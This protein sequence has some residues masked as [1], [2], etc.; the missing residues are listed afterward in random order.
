[1][2]LEVF[3]E[4]VRKNRILQKSVANLRQRERENE[5]REA[6][7]KAEI[8]RLQAKVG[9]LDYEMQMKVRKF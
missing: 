2:S 1:M 8:E 7:F 9:R 5:Q 3:A 4:V 6:E